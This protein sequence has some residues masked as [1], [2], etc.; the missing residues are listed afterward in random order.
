MIRCLEILGVQTK[1]LEYLRR[2]EKVFDGF[3][4]PEELEWQGPMHRPMFILDTLHERFPRARLNVELTKMVYEWAIEYQ[5]P[6]QSVLVHPATTM[7]TRLNL[8]Y[9]DDMIFYQGFK[10]DLLAVLTSNSVITHLRIVAESRYP[11]EYPA[12]TGVF[13]QNTLPKLEEL[14]LYVRDSPIFTDSKLLLWCTQG[15]LGEPYF[16]WFVPHTHISHVH[17]MDSKAE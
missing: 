10:K 1:H 17:W 16:S 7:S 5:L 15:G 9:D 13:K 14:R 3:A 2:L 6:L 4:K 11:D 8:N 12:M